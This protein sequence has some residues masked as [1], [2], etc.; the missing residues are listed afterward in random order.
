MSNGPIPLSLLPFHSM[1]YSDAD[2]ADILKPWKMYIF[3]IPEIYIIG[4]ILIYLL[5]IEHGST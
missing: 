2:Y 1:A 4:Y 3:L 5:Y